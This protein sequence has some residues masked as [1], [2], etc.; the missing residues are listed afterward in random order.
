MRQDLII[1]TDADLQTVIDRVTFVNTR[2]D[3]NWSY[4]FRPL[5]EVG[6][7]VWA[8]FDRPDTHSGA[9][10]RGR[11]RDEIVYRGASESS[12]MKTCWLLVELLVRHELM[13]GFRYEDLRVF[14]PH[15]T[16]GDLQ[17]AQTV[18]TRAKDMA[19]T[20]MDRQAEA[21]AEAVVKPKARANS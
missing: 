11:G 8:A 21:E 20:Y 13:E 15:N 14:D 18:G 12:V 9:V 3:W 2:L 7:L 16:I 6:W 4:H 1:N 19:C 5:G 10:G 17:L